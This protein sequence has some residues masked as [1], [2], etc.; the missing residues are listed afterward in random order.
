MAAGVF[1]LLRREEFAQAKQNGS[2]FGF[3]GGIGHDSM[4]KWITQLSFL[5]TCGFC[6]ERLSFNYIFLRFLFKDYLLII[7]IHL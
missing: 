2:S 3:D 4:P 5:N 7:Y 1:R 6:V